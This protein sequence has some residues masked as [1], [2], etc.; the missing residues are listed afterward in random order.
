MVVATPS[1]ENETR[2]LLSTCDR[3]S[4]PASGRYPRGAGCG[5]TVHEGLDEVE[6]GKGVVRRQGKNIAI[7][8]FG[9][10]ATA[11]QQAA[12]ALDATVVDMRFV[13][14]LDEA[15]L[16]SLAEDRKSTRLNSRH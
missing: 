16:Q 8:A 2:L 7:L 1:D 13:K 4:G 12:Q 6:L 3:H 15:L 11:A 14:P 10:L 5:A 9:T